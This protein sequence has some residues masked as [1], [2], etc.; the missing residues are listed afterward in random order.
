M[1]LRGYP[2]LMVNQGQKA[3]LDFSDSCKRSGFIK[4]NFAILK[5]EGV[6]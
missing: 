6:F 3:M 2:I 1:F 4:N 5:E